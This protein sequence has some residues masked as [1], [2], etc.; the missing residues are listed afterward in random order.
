M[1]KLQ[2]TTGG[3][4]FVTLCIYRGTAIKNFVVSIVHSKEVI[5]PTVQ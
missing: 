5:M 2:K 1:A 3:Y 4:F